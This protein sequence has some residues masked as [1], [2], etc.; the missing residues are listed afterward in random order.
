MKHAEE[1]TIEEG[2]TTAGGHRLALRRLKPAGTAPEAPWMVLLHEGLGS[3]AQWK[4]LPQRLV[5]A[6]GL[7]A[8]VYD[9][10]GFGG[11]EP[12]TLPRPDDY[13]TREAGEAL[14]ELL[15][16]EGIER[17]L[18]IGHSDGATIALLYAALF[19]ER[20]LG[21]VSMAAHVFVEEISLA[22]IR[23]AQAAWDRGDLARR[24]ARYHSEKTE[25]VFRGWA[26][27]WLRPSFRDWQMLNHLP[28]IR[29]PVLALQGLDDHYGSPRQ[30]ELIVQGV[31]GPA[32]PLLLPDCGHAPHL[33]APAATLTA[34]EGFLRRCL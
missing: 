13:L 9:R 2:T 5:A 7:P 3:I 30:V 33:E 34:I 25:L 23:Q 1:I 8:L 27:T 21:L 29:C 15:V 12:L 4:D 10:W 18:L 24:L 28:A 26:E 6:T 31:G 22:G 17:P 19:P 11:S 14:P 20:P 32:E 16:Q